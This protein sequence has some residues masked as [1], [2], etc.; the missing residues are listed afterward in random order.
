M[1]EYKLTMAFNV[2]DPIPLFV[3][4]KSRHDY[5]PWQVGARDDLV[6]LIAIE[7]AEDADEAQSA[8]AAHLALVQVWFDRARNPATRLDNGQ[9]EEM[10]TASGKPSRWLELVPSTEPVETRWRISLTFGLF[11]VRS[12]KAH[13]LRAHLLKGR[14]PGDLYEVS[15]R[16]DA[17]GITAAVVVARLD[18]DDGAALTDAVQT[19]VEWWLGNR[20]L[21]I[22]DV[23]RASNYEQI[24]TKYRIFAEYTMRSDQALPPT[25]V[26]RRQREAQPYANWESTWGEA[27]DGRQTITTQFTLAM[28][29]QGA[30]TAYADDVLCNALDTVGLHEYVSSSII[31]A[32]IIEEDSPAIG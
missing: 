29:D 24:N 7:N 17:G 15:L 26:F 2:E 30:A 19:R 27:E 10:G 8:L 16:I 1:P 22:D 13:R 6:V 4:R 20:H 5:A 28:D 21:E 12:F 31:G 11:D 32:E 9:V 3:L 25:D 23:D 14:V 18:G